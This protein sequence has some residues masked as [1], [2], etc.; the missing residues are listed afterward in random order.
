MRGISKSFGQVQANAAVDFTLRRSE[1]HAIVGENGAGKSTLMKILYG[2]YQP[3]E[4]EIAVNG[5]PVEVTSTRRAMR[6]GLG[7]I[8]QHFT[9][10]PVFTALQNIIL[11]KEPRTF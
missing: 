4:G 11:A 7:M 5:C 2:L 9:L 3:D 1:I 6:L 10:I 8:L